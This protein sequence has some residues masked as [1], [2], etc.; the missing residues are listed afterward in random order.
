MRSVT[1]S[2]DLRDRI[3]HENGQSEIPERW[4]AATLSKIENSSLE[5]VCDYE[6]ESSSPCLQICSGI[7]CQVAITE[8]PTSVSWMIWQ[9][10]HLVSLVYT[11]TDTACSEGDYVDLTQVPEHYT[12]Y[13]GEKAHRVWRSI[14]EENCFG[15]SE[16]DVMTGRS[17][18]GFALPDTM[19]EH[20]EEGDEQCLEK[21]IYYKII[22]GVLSDTSPDLRTLTYV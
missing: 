15:L 18:P 1:I 10:C 13:S 20:L 17:P 14:Y 9:V 21:R 11:L 2:L 16:F 22:S 5:N 3:T 8:T 4:Q 6:F 12:G 7:H 19:N